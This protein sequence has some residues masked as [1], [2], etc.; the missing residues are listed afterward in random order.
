MSIDSKDIS[1]VVQGAVDAALTPV[2]LAS[3]RK[4]L[5]EAEIILSTWEDSIVDGLDCDTLVFSKDP[6]GAICDP[7]WKVM[8]N[9]NRQIES[10]K[11]GLDA[12]SRRFA[13][14]IRSDMEL[15][16]LRCVVAWGKYDGKRADACRVFKNR[17][18]INNLYCANPYRTNF[19]FHISDWVQFGL[20]EDILNLWDIPHQSEHDMGKYW[21][22]KK[23][24]AI[25]PI[26][27]WYFRY[28]PEQYI[29]TECLRKNGVVFGFEYHTDI[30]SENLALSELSFANN[31]VILDYEESG[32]RFL[33]FDP[34]KWDYTAQYKHAEWLDLYK[35]HCDPSFVIPARY[36]WQNTLASPL[37][38][39]DV[40]RLYRHTHLFL[41][42]ILNNVK[43]LFRWVRR[44]FLV[45]IYGIKVSIL[46]I[47]AI[48]KEKERY[49]R[50]RES[51]HV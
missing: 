20:R 49:R 41:A 15:A 26:P 37:I 28:I 32:L 14:K 47:P 31:V 23:R 24:P 17:I 38:K 44:P 43:R 8:N 33:K 22:N 46:L 36:V 6:G 5:P 51:R 50:M 40:Q 29:W 12:A 9:V 4:L 11:K 48:L 39:K 13:M 16:D 2:C 34:Y 3:I 27:T 42:P 35:K 45:V 19:L 1:V 25:D 10:S 7:T 30:T 21:K 18:I